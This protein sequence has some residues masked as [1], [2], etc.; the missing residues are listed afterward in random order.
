MNFIFN[1][2]FRVLFV[3]I[4][5]FISLLL[6]LLLAGCEDILKLVVTGDGNIKRQK[7]EITSIEE[8]ELT[9]NF[10]LEIFQ[11]DELELYVDADENLLSYIETEIEDDKLIIQRKANY[12]L[13]PR[14]QIK[15]KL[16]VDSLKSLSVSEGGSLIIDT[17]IS[18]KLEIN[19]YSS[20]YISSRCLKADEFI[21]YSDGSNSSSIK[22]C[23]NSVSVLQLGSGESVFSGV[24]DN[25]VLIQKGS[26]KLDSY[27]LETSKAS[28]SLYGSGLVY[29][30]SK[31]KLDVKISGIGRV[32]YI[33]NPDLTSTI[34]GDGMLVKYG[35]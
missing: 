7:R 29:C 26:G 33:G 10:I 28:V 27:D 16:Y 20:S 1:N 4:S 9:E 25:L 12:T 22:G 19:S 35:N 15:L 13:S 17:F 11:S 3:K 6:L 14:K 5:L 30:N 2:I 23:F 31:D 34:V 8:V 21:F 24:T 32:Y 18:D